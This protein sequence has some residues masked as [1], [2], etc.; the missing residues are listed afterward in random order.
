M[1][2]GLKKPVVD[3]FRGIFCVRKR[4]RLFTSEG[5]EVYIYGGCCLLCGVTQCT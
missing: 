4:G 1:L 5:K 2:G 3:A